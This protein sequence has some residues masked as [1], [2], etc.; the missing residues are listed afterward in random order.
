MP[1]GGGG[2]E[3]QSGVAAAGSEVAGP[4]VEDFFD[5]VRRDLVPGDVRSADS[6]QDT[7]GNTTRV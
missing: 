2:A 3:H 6:V 4:A 1:S 5:F 7:D